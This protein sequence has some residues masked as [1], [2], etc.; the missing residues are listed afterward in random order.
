MSRAFAVLLVAAALVTG[1]VLLS[2]STEGGSDGEPQAGGGAP[3]TEVVD[4][5][6]PAA[7]QGSAVGPSAGSAT[8]GPLVLVGASNTASRRPDAFG[9]NGYKLPVTLPEGVTATLSVPQELRARVGLV[10]SQEAQTGAVA[11]GVSAADQAVSFAACLVNGQPGRSGWPGGI[12]VD[13]RQCATLTVT[14]AGRAPVNHRVPL[15]RR[16]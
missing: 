14:V 3:V 13:R 5:T 6:C 7:V 1:A 8:L 9:G 15:G 11:R 10:F 16:C 12:V 2:R 4:V